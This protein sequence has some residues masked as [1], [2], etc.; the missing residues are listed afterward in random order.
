MKVLACVKPVPDPSAPVRYQENGR[1]DRTGKVV[2]DEADSY[3]VEVALRLAEASGGSVVLGT[4]SDSSD[5]APLRAALA[6]GAEEALVASDSRLG[7]A[8]ALTTA[9]VL[10]ALVRRSGAEVV[11]TAT[12]S[13]DGYTGTVA[14]QLAEVLGWPALTFASHV[15]LEGDH[16]VVRRQSE[17]GTLEVAAPVPCVISVTAGSVEPRYAT[18]KG[19]VAAKSRPV[20][21]L[22]L[23]ELGVVLDEDRVHDVVDVRDAPG[24]AAGEKIVDE[25]QA[26]AAIVAYFDALKIL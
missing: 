23:D 9:R 17:T 3:G 7:G 5:P 8:D 1:L 25:G 21:T 18:F 6:M 14:A 13:A 24:R 26:A 16:V 10:G 11:V 2:L 4:M 22:T 20:T 15:S 12:E 19:I